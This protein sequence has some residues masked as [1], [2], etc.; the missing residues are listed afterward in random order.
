MADQFTVPQ[1]IEH[2]AKV[3]GPLTF[4]QFIY[5]GSAGAICFFF[6]FTVSFYMFV[7]ISIVVMLAGI[8]LAFGKIRGFPIVQVLKSFLIF[9]AGPKIYFWK[10]KA[11]PPPKFMTAP[12]V[13]PAE[14]IKRTPAP[15][16]V[17]KSRL[18]DLSKQL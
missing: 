11:G 8:T 6:Y 16:M 10:K 1:F 2:K 15:S 3:V 13:K 7:L 12:E 17:E 18:K 14:E 5:I 4:N 9:S